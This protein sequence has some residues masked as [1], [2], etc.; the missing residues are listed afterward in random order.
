[1]ITV[2]AKKKS[3]NSKALA[4]FSY[5]RR[6]HL[7][8]VL[9][10]LEAQKNIN[11]FDFHLFC[12]GFKNKKD[13]FSVIF[14][15]LTASVWAA[16]TSSR[17]HL[18][19]RNQGL[20]SSIKSGVDL[21]LREYQGVTVVEDDLSLSKNFLKFHSE[22]LDFYQANDNVYQIS[23][24]TFVDNT[25]CNS[26]C[27]F[28]ITS[29]WGW[30]TWPRA[31]K[32]YDSSATGWP[33]DKDSEIRNRFDLDGAYPF[34]RILDGRIQGNNQSWGILWYWSVFK[35]NGLVVYPPVSLVENNGFDG[36]G[37]HCAQV[38]LEKINCK[39]RMEISVFDFL[40]P[41]RP[42]YQHLEQL[43]KQLSILNK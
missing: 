22:C 43:K 42:N 23:G 28:P 14:N 26:T 10:D 16:R 21:L 5:N 4:V 36:S 38:E 12:D 30:S 9:A 3:Q 41:A 24:H 27:F 40:E 1:L 29:T 15:M 33:V 6:K 34:S 7:S 20:A 25:E 8:S 35:N 37:T 17:L 19:T 2:S 11:D 18:K 32:Y 39:S 31:W 13:L